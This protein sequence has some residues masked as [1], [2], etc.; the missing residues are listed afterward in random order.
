[1]LS[2]LLCCTRAKHYWRYI[3]NYKIGGLRWHTVDWQFLFMKEFIHLF[4]RWLD[5][6]SILV[7]SLNGTGSEGDGPS[8]S[9]LLLPAYCYTVLLC[10]CS[11]KIQFHVHIFIT[12][13]VHLIIQFGSLNFGTLNPYYSPPI[14]APPPVP[15]P[16]SHARRS[17]PTWRR[18]TPECP[19]S[20]WST[21]SGSG[22]TA[23]TSPSTT[24]TDR[25]SCRRRWSTPTESSLPTLPIWVR[26]AWKRLPKQYLS[27]HDLKVHSCCC[28]QGKF[29]WTGHWSC[30]MFVPAVSGLATRTNWATSFGCSRIMILLTDLVVGTWEQ[31]DGAPI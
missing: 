28:S 23:A 13:Y 6:N 31:S 24:T 27:S 2:Q 26:S 15:W 18:Q 10:S 11:Y 29:G 25:R 12:V 3:W 4:I 30:W 14:K 9:A 19:R 16:A 7:E 5:Y 21:T 22:S 8:L 17:T 1:M 20:C